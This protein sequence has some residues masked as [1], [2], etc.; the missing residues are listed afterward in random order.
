MADSIE[1]FTDGDLILLG[2]NVPHFLKNDPKFEAGDKNLRAKGVIIQFEKDFLGHALGHYPALFGIN[3][4]LV[5]AKRGIHFGHDA[6]LVQLVETLPRLQ[7]VAQLIALLQLLERMS[8]TSKRRP[9]GSEYFYNHLSLST[10]KRIEKVL[11]FVAF[12]YKEP[13]NLNQIATL[14][15]MNATAFCRY[16]KQKAG[17]SFK[18]YII[19]LRIGYACKLLTTDEM[20]IFQISIAC[21]FN[22]V[23]NFNSIFK[24]ITGHSPSNY[25][26]QVCLS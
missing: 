7:G 2:Q 26:R 10:D 18:Q 11:S 9:L 13:I 4:L 25:R 17:K 5:D 12:H 20:N 8:H 24:R 23:S 22:S 21:G 3:A 19:E 6:A 15:A 14:A 16:F 1:P